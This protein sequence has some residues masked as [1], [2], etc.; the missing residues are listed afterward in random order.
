MYY[1]KHLAFIPPL[2]QRLCF[3]QSCIILKQAD[4]L[5]N[6]TSTSM[7]LSDG[8]VSKSILKSAG[9]E[10]QE[11]IKQKYSQHKPIQH[12]RV[13]VTKAY[14]IQ[15]CKAVFHGALPNW[16]GD[17]NNDAMCTKVLLIVSI[18]LCNIYAPLWKRRGILLCTCRSVCRYVGIPYPCATDNSRMICPRSFKFGR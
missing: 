7:N 16:M 1:Y 2:L 15:Q 6:T 14:K 17:S 12:G 18:S 8:A 13:A 9:Q 10:I 3:D 5:V 11:E 4:V